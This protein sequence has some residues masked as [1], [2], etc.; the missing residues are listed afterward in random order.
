MV[1]RGPDLARNIGIVAASPEGAALFYRQISRQA[2]RLLP[3]HEHP[4]IS[5]HNEP[6]AQ[7]IDAIRADDWHAVGRLLRRSAEYL[8]R[9]G[10]AFAISP[11]NAVQHGIHLAEVGS[12]V[13][14]LAMPDLVGNRVQADGRRCVGLIG[15]RMVTT[16][17]TYQTLLGIRGTKVIA[18]DARESDMLDEIIFG[19]LI[20]GTIR[21]ESQRAV[22][23]VIQSLSRRGA[24]GVILGCSEAPLLVTPENAGMPIYDAADILAEEAVRFSMRG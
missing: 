16:G 11:D 17:S 5:I 22:L 20:Y 24:E 12:P 8:A 13:P 14:W 23:G 15:T 3:P 7:Y 19:E 2:S 18:P 1:R 21:P 10:A 6:L 9:C 4:A